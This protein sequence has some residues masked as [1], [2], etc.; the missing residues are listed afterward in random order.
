MNYTCPNIK[1]S[2]YKKPDFINKSGTYFRANDSRT[3]Q[4]F[5][6]FSCNKRFSQ[7]TFSLAYGQKKRRVNYQVLKLLSSSVSMRRTATLL[8]IHELTVKRKLIYLAKKARLSQNKFLERIKE[9]PVTH[10]QFDDLITTHHTKLKPLSVTIVVDQKRRTILGARVSQIPSFGKLSQISVRKYGKRKSY[11]LKTMN[12]LFKK[13]LPSI[14]KIPVIETDEHKHYPIMIKKYFPKAVHHSYKSERSCV[15][16][17]GELKKVKF[18][19]LFIINHT[20]AM[21][22]ANINRLVRRTWCTTKDPQ[23]LQNHIDLFIDFYN[24]NLI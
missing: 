12:L 6:C 10:L 11:H 23:M 17:Q 7:A 20:C 2:S 1:C 13:L 18:D 24:R 22:R 3:I 19:P 15:A 14:S 21:F 4:R 9:N 5:K 16:G 8:N